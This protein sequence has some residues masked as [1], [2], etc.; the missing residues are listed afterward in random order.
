MIRAPDVSAI[1][2]IMPTNNH[3]EY[4]INP[5]LNCIDADFQKTKEV[6]QVVF[7]LLSPPTP[8]VIKIWPCFFFYF[9][10]IFYLFIIIYYYFLLFFYYFF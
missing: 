7:V 5:G 2:H 10:I 4:C 1:F 6:S 8:C 3:Y 9:F